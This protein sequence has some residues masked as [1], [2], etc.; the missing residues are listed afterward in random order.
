MVGTNNAM[1]KAF[2]EIEDDRV[3]KFL[4]TQSCE[5]ITWDFNTPNASHMGGVWE[6]QIRTVRSI[7]ASLMKSHCEALNDEAFSTLV[8][9]VECIIN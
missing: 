3:G 1:K 9:E 6:R 7:F 5:W 8:K 2:S 4:H